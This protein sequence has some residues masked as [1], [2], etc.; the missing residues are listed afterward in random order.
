MT[1]KKQTTDNTETKLSL[2]V[3]GTS[4]P[5]SIIFRGGGFKIRNNC[6]RGMWT[7]SEQNNLFD[8]LEFTIIQA[9]EYFGDLGQTENT[10]WL[11]LYL[12]P[13]PA[14]PKLPENLVC[15]TYIKTRS[16]S[17]F[18]TKLTYLDGD[19]TIDYDPAIGIFQTKFVKHDS[20]LGDYFSLQFDWRERQAGAETEQLEKI[21]NFINNQPAL[22]D[23]VGTKDMVC[24]HGIEA[25]KKQRLIEE[26]KNRNGLEI[27][28]AKVL[29]SAG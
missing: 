22:I 5:G 8:E 13:V 2:S 10:E 12:V 23:T 29:P 3:L 27:L 7:D 25:E 26:H 14:T 20:K 1:T 21:I 19:K 18:E 15:C 17:S 9:I 24:I 6:K 28:D 4:T 11:Q 16:L